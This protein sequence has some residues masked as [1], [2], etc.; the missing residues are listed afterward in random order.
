MAGARLIVIG[1]SGHG[2]VAADCATAMGT[3]DTIVFLDAGWPGL[4]RTGRWPVI[5]SERA[6]FELAGER[7]EVFVAIG[8]SL[9]RRNILRQ[10]EIARVRIASISHPSAIVSSDGAI[11][12]GCLLAP[13]SIVNIGSRIG[14]GCIVNTG[15]SVDHDCE[16]GDGV[17][18]C[19]GARLAGDVRVG[20]GSWIGIGAAVRQG[21]R[22]GAGVTI[23]AG[24]AV[25]CDIADGVTAVGTPA[26]PITR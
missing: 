12:P 22:I 15:A 19:P 10:L 16:L 17:H 9:I 23:G 4:E 11:G 8:A 14:I 25:V 5:G 2:R 6:V 20:E 26:R 7:D 3:W 21:I 18:I 1:A 24:A 13:G